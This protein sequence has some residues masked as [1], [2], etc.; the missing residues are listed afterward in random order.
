LLGRYPSRVATASAET[1]LAYWITG[2]EQG[3]LREETLRE[4]SNEEVLVRALFSA[5]SRGTER[6]VFTG[7]I[8]SS[9][10]E[11]MRA[12]FQVGAFTFP[13]KYGYT[14]VGEVVAGPSDLLG[15]NVFCLYPHQSL[16]LVPAAS[17]SPLPDELPA[18]RA[19]LA[20]NMETALNAL[21]D[22][23]IKLGERVNVLGAG[24]VGCLVAYLAA[25][26]AGTE[27]TLVDVD[28]RKAEVAR[29]LGI[30]FALPDVAP[31]ECDLLLNASGNGAAL[32]SA[33][34]LAAHEARIIELS[35]FG[36]QEITLPLGAAFHVKRLTLR[37]SQVGAIPTVQRPRWDY[38]RRLGLALTL[39]CDEVLDILIDSEGSL[40]S[41]PTDMK[42]L[43]SPDC[44][45]L[46][47][48]VRYGAS[49]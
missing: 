6:L 8:P 11:R 43:A 25:R 5:V 46:C 29:R 21:W 32:R 18:A 40:T 20:A 48:R 28:P 2:A 42:R 9:E 16:Y 39:L 35:W 12:P 33:L 31:A 45:A 44:T 13:V 3:E 17:V 14:S 27:V 19:V 22:A 49:T 1:A 24:V 26:V 34:E 15:R 38:R 41:L 30:A 23:E 4:R 10:H 37:S 7:K 36:T 47:H